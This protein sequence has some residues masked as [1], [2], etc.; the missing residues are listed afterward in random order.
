[1]I[2]KF[3]EIFYKLVVFGSGKP[4]LYFLIGPPAVGKSTW[5]KNNIPNATIISRDDLVELVAEES[6]IGTY[7]DMFSRPNV[8][9]EENCPTVEVFN[10]AKAGDV[11]SNNFIDEYLRKAQVAADK[12][13]LQNPELISRFGEVSVYSKDDLFKVIGW[14]VPP[15]Y[16]KP[17]S[18]SK[19]DKAD[20]RI[21][22]LLDA[23]RIEA[24]KSLG[25]MVI[26]M[27]NLNPGQRQGHIEFLT[28]ALGQDIK[29]LYDIIAVNFA[30]AEGYSEEDKAKIKE[31]AKMRAEDAR[32]IGKNKTIPDSVFDRMFKSYQAP[33]KE[34]D[35]SEIINVGIPSITRL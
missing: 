27:T 11:E 9:F 6:G 5:I 32:R 14:G 24:A 19:I 31:V 28:K 7:D 20:Q 15:E 3:A 21:S 29:E 26:D 35:F 2:K 16:I 10:S 30:P 23:K 33:Q 22:E 25:D 34:E 17:F 13:N 12:F 4:R 1:M 8:E 18:Y